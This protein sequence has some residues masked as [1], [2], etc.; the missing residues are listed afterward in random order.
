M[1]EQATRSPAM[2][3]AH[4]LRGLGRSRSLDP[5]GLADEDLME[6]VVA[7]DTRAFATLYDR[8]AAVAYSL[9]YRICGRRSSAEEVV[10]EAFL[11]A[12]RSRASYQSARGGLRQWILALVRNRAID[13]VRHSSVKTSRDVQDDRLAAALPALERTDVE[14]ERRTDAE[15]VRHALRQLPDDQQ[16]VIELAFFGGFTHS[17]IAAMLGLPPGTVKGRMRLGLT[18]LQAML[19]EQASAMV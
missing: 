15:L 5:R 12:W 1:S 8:H 2:A 11:A 6:L 4:A 16:R 10:Q 9:A 19:G 14:V 13:A 3:L 18:K 7:G 17:E